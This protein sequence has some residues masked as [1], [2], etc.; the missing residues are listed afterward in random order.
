MNLV[1]LHKLYI[2][3]YT[4]DKG[5]QN[6]PNLDT[7]ESVMSL[8]VDRMCESDNWYI[9]YRPSEHILICTF[10]FMFDTSLTITYSF[11][12]DVYIDREWNLNGSG[13][14]SSYSYLGIFEYYRSFHLGSMPGRRTY[15]I[16]NDYMTNVFIHELEIV[17]HHWRQNFLTLKNLG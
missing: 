8:E 15:G 11:G 4:H 7:F 3:K 1:D 12:E 9:T 17:K 5:V 6:T 2:S 10:N 14:E 16:R 13:L